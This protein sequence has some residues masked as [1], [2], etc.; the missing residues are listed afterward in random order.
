[1]DSDSELD[2]RMDSSRGSAGG[3]GYIDGAM[4]VCRSERLVEGADLRYRRGVLL[5]GC[6]CWGLCGSMMAVVV[7]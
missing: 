6:V 7:C 2:S 4:V 5:V 3:V 1:M